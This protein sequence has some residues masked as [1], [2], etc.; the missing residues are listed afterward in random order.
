MKSSD[1]FGAEEFYLNPAITEP[2][3]PCEPFR[4]GGLQNGRFL[5]MGARDCDELAVVRIEI[6]QTRIVGE[7]LETTR[8]VLAQRHQIDP[9]PIRPV[10]QRP[11]YEGVSWPR[12][13]LRL[14]LVLIFVENPKIVV[15]R[16]FSLFHD[17]LQPQ[18]TVGNALPGEFGMLTICGEH[19]VCVDD[20]DF[21]GAVLFGALGFAAATILAVASAIS[22]PKKFSGQFS[23][24]PNPFSR[25]SSNVD[26]EPDRLT[27]YIATSSI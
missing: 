8:L 10:V 16:E 19:D 11:F 14:R 5:G 26:A 25:S 17:A 15:N 21:H 22:S 2:V 4:V 13:L 18:S 3:F 7:T 9:L 12:S 23:M 24:S 27:K 1:I 6:G 20:L